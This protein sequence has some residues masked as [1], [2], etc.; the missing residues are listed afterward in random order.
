MSKQLSKQEIT[1]MKN[2]KKDIQN[3]SRTNEGNWWN[4]HQ[5]IFIPKRKKHK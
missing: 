1:F 2:V 5:P 3:Q 4:K